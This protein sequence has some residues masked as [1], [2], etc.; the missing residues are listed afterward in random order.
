MIPSSISGYPRRYI[1]TRSVCG[2]IYF[3]ESYVNHL[4]R[5][6]MPNPTKPTTNMTPHEELLFHLENIAALLGEEPSWADKFMQRIDTYTQ[7]KEREA[8][9]N[10]R[11]TEQQ[12]VRT[13]WHDS[14]DEEFADAMNERVEYVEKL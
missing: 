4:R 7:A 13:N 9:L 3:L 2:V 1:T 10:A 12:I 5:L 14:T 6:L 8:A 11:L